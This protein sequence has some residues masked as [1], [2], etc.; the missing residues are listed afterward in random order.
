[1]L[2]VRTVIFQTLSRGI[3]YKTS[4]TSL[5]VQHYYNFFRMKIPKIGKSSKS[6]HPG[7]SLHAQHLACITCIVHSMFKFPFSAY[8]RENSQHRKYKISFQKMLYSFSVLVFIFYWRSI[9]IQWR[10]ILVVFEITKKICKICDKV[11]ENIL[12]FKFASSALK[13]NFSHLIT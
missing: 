7:V 13:T 2:Y 3:F 6:D 9:F 11:L 1:M 12:I 4:S 10:K 5:T 8:L